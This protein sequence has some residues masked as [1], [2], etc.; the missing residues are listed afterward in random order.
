[1][2]KYTI[3]RKGKKLGVKEWVSPRG[4]GEPARM[5]HGDAPATT[6]LRRSGFPPSDGAGHRP[7]RQF[8]K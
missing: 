3:M 2:D 7:G 8:K 6:S 5:P 4:Q 1:M